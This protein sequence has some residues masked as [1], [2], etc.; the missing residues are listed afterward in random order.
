VSLV[1]LLATARTPSSVTL[2]HAKRLRVFSAV[3]LLTTLPVGT[4][5]ASRFS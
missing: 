3:Q 5:C 1:Q 4:R 2:S